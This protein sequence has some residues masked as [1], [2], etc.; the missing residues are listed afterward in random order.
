MQG[1]RPCPPKAGSSAST[2]PVWPSITDML[3]EVADALVNGTDIDGWHAAV[4]D[5]RLDWRHD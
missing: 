4:D 5:D 2:Q 3:A 1:R